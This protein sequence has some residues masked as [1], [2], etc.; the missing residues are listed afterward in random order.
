MRVFV[1]ILEQGLV[2][3]LIGSLT[4]Y[5]HT[6]HRGA[7]HTRRKQDVKHVCLFT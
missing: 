4:S 2:V 3:A 1:E 7:I 6:L 5:T